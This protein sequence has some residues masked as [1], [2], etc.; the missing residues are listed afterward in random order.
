M[1]TL[2][3]LQVGTT[4]DW[5]GPTVAISL[6]VMALSFIGMAIA[7]A[8]AAFRVADQVKKVEHA[9]R[10]ASRTTSSEPSRGCTA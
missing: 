7:V 1:W 4:P 9:G 5:V 6:A 8:V 10:V 3:L 2:A